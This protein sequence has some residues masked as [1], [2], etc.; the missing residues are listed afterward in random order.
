MTIAPTKPIHP[1][2][3]GFGAAT[4][5][6]ALATIVTALAFEY[7]GGFAP[8]EL[9]LQQR[10]AYYAAIPLLFIALVLLTSDQP[11]FASAIFLL[12]AFAFLANAGLGVYQA[13]AEW[14]FWPGPET[15]GTSQ[16]V[17]TNA[18]D[19]LRELGT[20]RVIRCDEASFR[21]VGLSFA[22]WNVVVCLLLFIYSLKAASAAM[23]RHT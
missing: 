4:L 7:L 5:I 22:G 8:C 21:F 6:I 3:Y 18:S 9:C 15:C 13:G 2:G 10:Y 14:K 16:G 23:T 19:L 20:T 1:R 17:A 12:V 11:K